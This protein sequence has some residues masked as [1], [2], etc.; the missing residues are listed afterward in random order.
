MT[1]RTPNGRKPTADS[2]GEAK[3]SAAESPSRDTLLD[4]TAGGTVTRNQQARKDQPA[5]IPRAPLNDP[6][7]VTYLPTVVAALIFIGCFL[8]I[9][10]RWFIPGMSGFGFTTMVVR[11][12]LDGTAIAPDQYRFLMPWADQLLSEA[13]RLPLP[14]AIL[15]SDAA[16]LVALLVVLHL[17]S[18]RLGAP[19]LIVGA[20][21]GWAWLM[22]KIDQWDPQTM[23][24]AVVVAVATL[25]LLERRPQWWA[26]LVLVALGV[27]ACG[28]RTDYAASLGL[29]VLAAGLHR[30]QV[31]T[32]ITGLVIG[33]A[34]A[35][36]TVELVRVFPQARY[37]TSIMQLD[38]NITV[39]PLSFAVTFYGAFLLVP[40]LLALRTRS[41]PPM[42]FVL[43]LF[44]VEF[45]AVFVVGRT[46]ES[47]IFMPL[48]P[49]LGVAAVQAWR[50]LLAS[51]AAA[52]E[53][54][55][56]NREHET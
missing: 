48:A 22:V 34:A 27:L 17:L 38:Y 42:M 19:W 25:L 18:V 52:H 9:R 1:I 23:L 41:L 54:R 43:V 21:A 56:G 13:T 14:T 20:A 35:A 32:S 10:E 2:A 3:A 7:I 40:A 49:V 33:L 4:M 46:D 44:A 15:A 24:L 12:T 53:H 45:A 6:R 8:R 26:L 29:V 37:A 50:G 36:A 51:N 11:T 30:R 5:R 31:V 55:D 47:R 39:D 28:A 16:L